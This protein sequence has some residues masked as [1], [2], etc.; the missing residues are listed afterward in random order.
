MGF[1]IASFIEG[2]FKPAVKL[3]DEL[4]T[5]KEE[6]AAI[7]LAMMNAQAAA[8]AKLEELRSNIIVAEA[9]SK[10]FLTANWRPITMLSFVFML[11]WNYAG[12]P[13]L[14]WVSALFGGPPVPPVELPA[15]LWAVIT[16]GLGGYIGARTYEKV[17]GKQ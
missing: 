6:K 4:H 8:F 3:V 12:V 16:T 7:K 13:I 17:Q 14:S 5:S 15:G 11:V 2:I 1:N 9:N 10:H